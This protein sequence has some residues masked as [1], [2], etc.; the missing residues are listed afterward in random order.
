MMND[1]DLTIA[2]PEDF[3]KLLRLKPALAMLRGLAH[4]AGMLEA[5]D[6]E[7][8]DKLAMDCYE[9][10]ARA[11]LPEAMLRAAL[12][13]EAARGGLPLDT[14]RAQAWRACAKA[15]A[16]ACT[17]MSAEELLGVGIETQLPKLASRTV[18]TRAHEVPP[19]EPAP[20][21]D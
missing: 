6:A 16:A 18:S 14:A 9:E 7:P 15:H 20:P 4:E 10:A 12:F 3:A 13:A 1:K 5:S 2:V 19:Q 21:L 17:P 11:G 8:S